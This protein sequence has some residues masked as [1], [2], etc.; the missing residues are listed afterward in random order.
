MSQSEFIDYVQKNPKIYPILK[1]DFFISLVKQGLNSAVTVN[2]IKSSKEFA[3]YSKDDIEEALELL[4]TLG[5]FNQNQIRNGKIYNLSEI[6][7]ELVSIY[8]KARKEYNI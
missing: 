8:D 5:I 2:D 7:R 3:K 4:S 6:G 1:S